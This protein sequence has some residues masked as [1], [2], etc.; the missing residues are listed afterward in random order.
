MV[1]NGLAINAHRIRMDA[2]PEMQRAR[3]QP[4]HSRPTPRGGSKRPRYAPYLPIRP[5]FDNANVIKYWASKCPSPPVMQV[6][7]LKAL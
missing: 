7:S 3:F 1:A 4:V 5:A 2:F 6:V